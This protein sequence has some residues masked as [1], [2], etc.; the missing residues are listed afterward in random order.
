MRQSL[1][2]I[3]FCTLLKENKFTYYIKAQKTKKKLYSCV[4]TELILVNTSVIKICT[5]M[6]Q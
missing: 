1:K 3:K 5:V 2:R 4:K 6:K